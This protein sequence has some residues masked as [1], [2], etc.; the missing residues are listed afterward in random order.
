MGHDGGTKILLI[1]FVF[2]IFAVISFVL[3]GNKLSYTASLHKMLF[4]EDGIKMPFTVSSMDNNKLN[5]LVL[6]PAE[7]YWCT[8]QEIDTGTDLELPARIRIV[9]WDNIEGCCVKL[10]SGYNCA[11]GKNI[12]MSFCYTGNIG[13]KVKWIIINGYYVNVANYKSFFDDIDKQAIPNKPCDV[14]KYQNEL[15]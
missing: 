6:P 1:L 7:A 3:W 5:E 12:E 14:S 4:G 8:V 15:K 9:G 10:I 2:L 13:G 11:L